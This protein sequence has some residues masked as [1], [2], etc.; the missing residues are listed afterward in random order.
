MWRLSLGHA[1]QGMRVQRFRGGRPVPGD[2]PDRLRA[3][4]VLQ[5]H[6]IARVPASTV[7]ADLRDLA[8]E[9]LLSSGVSDS[10][11]VCPISSR[12]RRS[13]GGAA[14]VRR[15]NAACLCS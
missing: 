15:T 9:S 1:V 13:G 8:R 4:P 6:Y 14:Q 3:D 10:D 5:D 7:A 11:W 12:E 2:E